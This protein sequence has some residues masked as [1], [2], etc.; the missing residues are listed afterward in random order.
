MVMDLMPEGSQWRSRGRAS[1]RKTGAGI[2]RRI[3]G[4][5]FWSVCQ[6][7]EFSSVEKGVADSC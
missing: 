6:G 4:A 2:W 7:P 1:A 3:Y 5:D